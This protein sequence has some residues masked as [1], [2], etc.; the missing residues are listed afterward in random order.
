VI[1]LTIKRRLFIANIIMV[2]SPIIVTA[3][4]FFGIRAVVVSDDAQTRGGLGGRF[5]D[6]P[7][8]PVVGISGADEAFA[9]GN[10]DYV[11]SDIALYH[12]DL[13]DFI[14]VIPD[15]YWEAFD[16]FITGPDFMLPVILFYLLAVVIVANILLARYISH[17]VMAPIN[18]LSKGVHE[19]T[20]GN[21][22]HRIEYKVG[23]EFDAVCADFNTMASRLLEMVELRQADETSRRELIAGI[24]HDLRTPL[25][26][27]KAYIEG[28]KKGIAQTPE[29]QE[30][31]LDIIQSKTE[32][33]E[34]IIKQ[35]FMFSKLDVGD[36]P[37]NLEAIDIENE[38]TK[39]IIGLIDEYREIGLKINLHTDAYGKI[40][41]ID[42]VQFKNIIENI[43]GNSVK[44][45]N[46]KDAKAWVYCK[47]TSNDKV[48]IIIE[49]NGPGVPEEIL[50]KMFDIFFRGD[51]SRNNPAKG[52]G[53]GLAISS[54][55][56]QGMKGSIRAENIP[57]GGLRVIITLPIKKGGIPGEENTYN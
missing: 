24:S 15:V 54:K 40:V 42:M 26:S 10:F 28:L 49:D 35:L 57:E 27:V 41:V 14:V 52:S 13:G 36:F 21:L 6:M 16:D 2:L 56:I 38:L 11:T 20:S 51:V 12:S 32:D 33:I 1:D 47:K 39:L 46:R 3:I 34:Y 45:C 7:S 23:D 53:L 18:T 5:A 17:R 37:L 55:I 25:T 9:R 44:Y 48:S 50:S 31:Y 4:I 30:K 8:I 22:T 43:L 19:I 29:K